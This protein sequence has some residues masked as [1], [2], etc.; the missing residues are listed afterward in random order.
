MRGGHHHVLHRQARSLVHHLLRLVK[1]ATADHTTVRDD[2]NELRFAII[3]RETSRM[4]LIMN[5]S[6]LSILKAAIDRA[7]KLR[8]DVAGGCSSAE[9]GGVKRR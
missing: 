6:G 8:R 2:E 3:E 5:V 7:A 1:D 4:Q 9:L